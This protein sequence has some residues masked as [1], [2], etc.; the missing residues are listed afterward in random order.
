MD[1]PADP[2]F[3]HD[4]PPELQAMLDRDSAL[5]EKWAR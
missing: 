1:A 5:A 2:D 3:R 4:V